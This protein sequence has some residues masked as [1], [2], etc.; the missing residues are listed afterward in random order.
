[1]VV[2]EHIH[3]SNTKLILPVIFQLCVSVLCVLYVYNNNKEKKARKLRKSGAAEVKLEE[4]KGIGG[5]Y[6]ILY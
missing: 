3:T 1:M 4:E 2:S 6:V 5:N